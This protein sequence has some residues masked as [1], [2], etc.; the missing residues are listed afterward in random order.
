MLK[1]SGIELELILEIDTHLLIE[2]GMRSGISY[3]SKTH[4]KANNKY[5]KCYG[6]SKESKY[7]TYLDANNIYGWVMSQYLPHSGFKWFNQK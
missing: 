7:I 2:K 4:S 6:S 5:M 1:M 3:V